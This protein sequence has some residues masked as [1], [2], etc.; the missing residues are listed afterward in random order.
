LKRSVRAKAPGIAP[1]GSHARQGETFTID[2]ADFAPSW[3][4]PIDWEPPTPAAYPRRL[5]AIDEHEAAI[6]A[7]DAEFADLQAKTVHA[8]SQMK[9]AAG[10]AARDAA[11]KDQRIAD[12]EAEL[13]AAKATVPPPDET[14]TAEPQKPAAKSK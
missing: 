11:A 6:A 5:V 8:L 1:G 13:A 9:E 10:D 12:L 2:E 7:K 14:K 4:D 3:M